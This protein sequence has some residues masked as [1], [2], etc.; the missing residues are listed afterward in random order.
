[1]RNDLNIIVAVDRAGGFGNNGKIP[2]YYKEDFKRFKQITDNS[3][4]IMGRKTAEEIY[5]K[6][7]KRVDETGILL[8]NRESYIISSKKLDIPK[9]VIFPS[10]REAVENEDQNTKQIFV[11]G[12]HL[13]FIEALPW[14]K[15]IYLTLINKRYQCDKFFPLDYLMN[16]FKI[17]SAEKVGKTVLSFIKYVKINK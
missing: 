7:K 15:N 11:L 12:G 17:E 16:N 5:E 10:L 13:L 3:I 8:P 9:A 6:N 1:M 2:W 4:C 14:T